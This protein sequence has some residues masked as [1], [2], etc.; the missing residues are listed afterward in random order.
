MGVTGL[1]VRTPGG[2]I[3]EVPIS[4]ARVRRSGRPLDTVLYAHMGQSAVDPQALC[5]TDAAH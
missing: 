1:A 5:S 4:H 3:P 2:G